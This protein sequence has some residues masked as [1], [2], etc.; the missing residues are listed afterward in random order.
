MGVAAAV[1]AAGAGL[2]IAGGIQ[3]NREARRQARIAREEA[4]EQAAARRQEVDRFKSKQIVSFLKSGVELQ[5]TPLAVLDETERE[6]QKEVSSILRAGQERSRALR[7]EGRTRLLQ[8]LSSGLSTGAQAL[9][10]M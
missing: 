5:G 7:L 6:G 2:N 1:Q 9:G 4:A 3:A 8:G 10:G